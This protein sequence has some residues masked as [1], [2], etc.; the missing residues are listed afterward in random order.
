MAFTG[1][2]ADA[3]D[4]YAELVD[5]NERGWW[6]ENKSRYDEQVRAPF[7]ALIDEL[8][9]E[10]GPL[11]V[12]RPYRDVRFAV[13]KRPYKEQVALATRGDEAMLYLQ[14][15]RDGLMLA[16][17]YYRPS[18]EQLG[19]FREIVDDL[20]LVGDLEATLDELAENGF[21]TTD[22]DALIT[23][24][25]G[26]RRDHPRIELLRLRN[27]AIHANWP[28]EAWMHDASALDR[29]RDGWRTMGIWN[30]WL[31]ESIG[32]SASLASLLG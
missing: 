6:L 2:P 24:P 7:T 18:R 27:L 15:N 9:P 21:T 19:R 28:R 30:T 25:R 16:G 10:F 26:Y 12:F 8:G 22:S 29:V 4:F 31:R 13:D 1:F 23:A 3:F 11:R 32:S 14:L 5:H 20:R 17:G